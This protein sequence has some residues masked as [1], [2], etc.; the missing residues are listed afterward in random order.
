MTRKMAH[1]NNNGTTSCGSRAL[2]KNRVSVEEDDYSSENQESQ[3]VLSLHVS[4]AE[5][6]DNPS[7]SNIPCDDRRYKVVVW[8]EPDNE[9]KSG[10]VYG[11]PNPKWNGKVNIKFGASLL[12]WGF[13]HVEVVGPGDKSEPGTSHGKSVSRTRIRLPK[14]N[15]EIKGRFGLVKSGGHGLKAEGYIILSMLASQ[16]TRYST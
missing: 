2:K 11:L 1:C 6:I 8:V 3:V 4:H 12:R 14:M 7:H 10:K 9:Y 16:P 5:D 15:E 13:L